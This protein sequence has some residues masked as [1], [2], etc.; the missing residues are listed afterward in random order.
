MPSTFEQLTPE[1]AKKLV[2]TNIAFTGVFADNLLR[3]ISEGNPDVCVAFLAPIKLHRE[4]PPLIPVKRRMR[5]RFQFVSN[6]HKETKLIFGNREEFKP[7][8]PCRLEVLTQEA[9]V[10]VVNPSESSASLTVQAGWRGEIIISDR[11]L[12]QSSR[13]QIFIWLFKVID[14]AEMV[15]WYQ[16]MQLAR[17]GVEVFFSTL[18]GRHSDFRL[19]EALTPVENDVDFYDFTKHYKSGTSSDGTIDPSRRDELDPNGK[20]RTEIWLDYVG[21]VGDGWNPT[22]SIAYWLAQR[23]LTLLESKDQQAPRR[24]TK[25]GDIL[26]FGGDQVYPIA[27]RQ[28]YAQRLLGPYETALDESRS[29]HPHAFAI[30]G[31]HDWYDSLVS[32]T[33][34]FCQRRW[35]AGWQTDQ[36]RSYFALK[37]P[38]GWWF[39]GTDVQLDS[40]IDVPQVNFFRK[41]AEKI[42]P[43]DRVIVC[44]AEPH[45]VYAALYG[46]NDS[47]FN[48]N[49]LAFFEKKVIPQ[50][51]RI[52]AFVAGDQH[53]YRR[54]QQPEDFTQ[55]ITAGGGGAFLHPT[56]G[57]E[58]S[59]LD[60]GFELKESYP[61]VSVSKR[62]GRRALLFLFFNFSFGVAT[63][64]LYLLTAWSVRVDISRYGIDD[65]LGALLASV[66]AAIRNPLAVFWILAAFIGFLLFTDTHSRIYRGVAGSLHGLAHLTLIFLIGWAATRWTVDPV[67][68]PFDSI[69][70]LLLAAVIIFV[71]GWILGSTLMGVYLYISLNWCRRHSNEAFSALA[72]EGWKNFLR[73]KIESNGRLTIYPI[74]LREVPKKWKRRE[75]MHRR[76][77]GS[78][79]PDY[80]PKSEWQH[81]FLIESPISFCPIDDGKG[82]VRI[83]PL[84]EDCPKVS[85]ED[86]AQLERQH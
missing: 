2:N 57:E 60:G 11:N 38:G 8:K 86:A 34:L 17:T 9:I 5:L 47:N 54:Y 75:G 62:L 20:E 64:A 56:H 6:G 51:A 14:P 10:L 52:V 59:T 13:K 33:R 78:R 42:E 83:I 77:D 40:D 85:P 58:A 63:A 69:G 82:S 43:G 15:G 19:M 41:V 39:L 45:W 46:K 25:R 65:P 81:P 68:S 16:P 49:N 76:E 23:E 21:D 1:L 4:F 71:L 18:F 53:H 67:R 61:E 44:T 72:V 3:E 31:N 84:E 22:Y 66:E 79:K 27:N 48:E 37:L 35:F 24:L 32:F 28:N 12:G 73:F 74:G 26:I 80:E 50:D 70:Q 29:P 36:S 30:P 7:N 55:K